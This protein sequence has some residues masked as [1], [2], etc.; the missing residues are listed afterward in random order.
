[1]LF[2]RIRIENILRVISS[3]IPHQSRLVLFWIRSITILTLF[4]QIQTVI[5]ISQYAIELHRRRR[6]LIEQL[7]IIG[8]LFQS[9]I[10]RRENQLKSHEKLRRK[11]LKRLKKMYD[12][13]KKTIDRR[14]RTI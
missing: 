8:N 14:V 5:S 4:L 10:H 9:T 3:F 1:M 6:I 13:T 12:E 2:F 11:T 7:H